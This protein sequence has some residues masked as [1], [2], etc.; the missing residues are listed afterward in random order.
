MPRASIVICFG[1]I[2]I[3]EPRIRSGQARGGCYIP[4]QG[5]LQRIKPE[6]MAGATA[7]AVALHCTRR[8]AS[9]ENPQ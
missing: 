7:S 2:V 9:G 3:T 1:R 5:L 8:N 4:D 6:P